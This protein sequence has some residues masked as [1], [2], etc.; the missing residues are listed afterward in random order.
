MSIANALNSAGSGLRATSRLASTISNNV[1]NAL[2]PS[3]GSRATELSSVT[4]GGGVRVAAT[5]RSTSPYL[6]A[7]RRLA[8]ADLGA[9]STRSDAYDRL[10]MAMGEAGATNSLA[11][12]TNALETAIMAAVASPQSTTLLSAAMEAARALS[13]SL[14]DIA[15][16]A[17]SVRTDADAQI[18]KQVETVNDALFR[19]EALNAKIVNL[20][21]SG[22]DT[23]SLQDERGRL[24]DSISAIVPIKTVNRAGGQVSLYT[25]NGATLLDSSVW[26]LSFEAAPTVVTS[27]MTLASGQVGALRQDQG[28]FLGLVTLATGVGAGPMDGGSLAAL[29]QVRDALVPEFTNELDAFARD[30]ISRFQDM[31]PVAALDADGNGLFV[32][33]GAGLIGLSA[34]LAINASVDPDQGGAVWR[35]RDGL[36]A[37]SQGNSGDATVLRAM[38]DSM[39]AARD[40]IGFISQSAGNN[41]AMMAS[42]I[43]SFFAGISARSDDNLAFLTARQSTLAEQEANATG[44]DSDSELEFLMIVE[45]AYAANA[46]V[47]STIDELMQLLLEI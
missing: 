23:L 45:Q 40:P 25:Q 7:E 3:Y 11:S 12:A 16:E 36:G 22:I 18:A 42:E 1:S 4:F 14:N 29:F 37:L 8:E 21:L 44:V 10:L 30:L 26:E 6:T 5:T 27:D 24:I 20:D 39:A 17:A 38:T 2:T 19:I 46:K 35:L 33:T 34:R 13:G 32:D 43:S 41:A 31:M 28:A 15:D 47:L 9:A